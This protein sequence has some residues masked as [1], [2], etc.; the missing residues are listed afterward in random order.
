MAANYDEVYGL[1]GVRQIDAATLPTKS[2]GGKGHREINVLPC[3]GWIAYPHYFIERFPL[4]Y[5]DQSGTC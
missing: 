4:K 2:E 1:V 3:Q 5:Q